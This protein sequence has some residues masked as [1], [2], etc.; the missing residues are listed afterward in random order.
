M[1]L[2]LLFGAREETLRPPLV[3][4]LLEQASGVGANQTRLFAFGP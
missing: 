3:G 2:S 4:R 1:K